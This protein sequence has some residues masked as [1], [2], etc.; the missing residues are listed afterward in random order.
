MVIESITPALMRTL[1][2]GTWRFHNR[3]RATLQP[4]KRC[5]KPSTSSRQ[6]ETPAINGEGFYAHA[7]NGGT[8]PYSSTSSPHPRRTSTSPPPQQQQRSL[9]WLTQPRAGILL[10]P[11]GHRRH[12]RRRLS[13]SQKGSGSSVTSMTTRLKEDSRARLSEPRGR[14]LL[15]LGLGLLLLGQGGEKRLKSMGWCHS[16]WLG[17]RNSRR[18]H[19]I[20]ASKLHYEVWDIFYLV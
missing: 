14:A 4:Y 11:R 8:I 1:F 10:Q 19:A 18:S 3:G 5:G 6:N 16:Y 20:A 13:S 2:P 7:N 15:L 9:A 17:H 12:R